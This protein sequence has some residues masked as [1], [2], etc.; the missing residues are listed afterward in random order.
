MPVTYSNNAAAMVIDYI[1][2][3]TV[4]TLAT[5]S[6]VDFFTVSPYYIVKCI[7]K[8]IYFTREEGFYKIRRYFSFNPNTAASD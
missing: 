2:T 7:V 1:K 8:Y 6:V 3:M 5:L 4:F